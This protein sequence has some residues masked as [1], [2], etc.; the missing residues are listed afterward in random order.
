MTKSPYI[1]IMAGG[2]GSRFWPASREDLPK[3]FLDITGSGKSLIRQT[4]DRFLRFIPLENIYIIT[5]QHYSSLVQQAIP[6]LARHQVIEEPARN[7]TAASIALASM[8]LSKL[9]PDAV[10][11]VAPA[12]H[13]I[14]DEVEFQRVIHTAVFHA[15]AE[16]SI[17]TLGIEPTRADTGYGYIEFDKTADT[18][19]R[20]VRSFREKPD[21]ATAEQY[22]NLGSFAWNAGIFIWKLSVILDSFRKHAPGIFNVL[23]PGIDIYN[24]SAETD[25]IATEYP[26][27]EKISVDYAILERADNVYTIPCD[28][29]WSD[30]GT[31]TSL[32]DYSPKDNAHNVC[33]SQPMY[34]DHARHN[35]ILSGNSKLVVIK[36]LEDFIV[37]DTENCLMIYPKSE[38]Q[39]IK[40]LKADLKEKGLGSFL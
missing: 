25:F 6:E 8:K 5:H 28:I 31:W 20:A 23:S 2:I 40:Q 26:K 39:A 15:I 4:V 9:N 33:L 35:L 13:V 19:V 1:L 29:G 12:D 11:I 17:I 38:E 14:S 37:I 34:L 32:Y 27:T 3:Q 21:K 16:A 24:T 18:P 7:N 36:G 10:C 30:L 22:L